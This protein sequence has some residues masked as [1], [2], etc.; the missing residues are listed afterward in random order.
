[1]T[2]LE[3]KY[4]C[5]AVLNKEGYTCVEVTQASGDQG[6]DVLAQKRWHIIRDSMQILLLCLTS[7]LSK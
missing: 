2:G 5:A 7:L 3:F 4:Y 6:I 1:M